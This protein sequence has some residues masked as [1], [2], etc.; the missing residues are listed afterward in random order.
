MLYTVAT[1]KGLGIEVWG[2]KEDL[3]SLYDIISKFWD[4]ESLSN[5]SGYEDKNNLIINF[6]YKIRKA[7]SGARLEKKQ[8]HCPL[9]QT[10]Y[11]GFLISWP[12]IMFVLSA[13]K[14][15]MSMTETTKLDVGVMFQLEYWVE[16]SMNEYDPKG[17]ISMQPFLNGAI[18]QGYDQLY[19]LMRHINRQFFELG[20]GKLSFRK[21]EDLMKI[22]VAFSP[23]Y[24]E[25]VNFLHIQAK[26]SQCRIEDLEFDEDETVY[27]IEW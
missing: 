26:E 3:E 6:S 13:L 12:N 16:K 25:F 18:Y 5:L 7:F 22:S 9:E 21:L 23:A 1:K 27:E 14:Y 17:A 19:W 4:N 2:T 8:R 15:N 20:G 10:S 11:L 24:E